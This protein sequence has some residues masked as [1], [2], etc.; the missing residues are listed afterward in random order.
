MVVKDYVELGGKRYYFRTLS[1]KQLAKAEK[2]AVQVYEKM[3]T[4]M[5]EA[6][7]LAVELIKDTTHIPEQEAN[8][9]TIL[10][11]GSLV[12]QLNAYWLRL[13]QQAAKIPW[14]GRGPWSRKVH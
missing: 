8:Q 1:G 14:R 12:S 3:G 10:Q 2:T 11:V 5:Q 9:L 13:A 4:D 7:R 6:L